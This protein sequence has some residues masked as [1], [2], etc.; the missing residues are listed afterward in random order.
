MSV[1][2]VIFSLTIFW[3]VNKLLTDFVKRWNLAY[4]LGASGFKA[5]VGSVMVLFMSPMTAKVQTRTT[6]TDT[7][8]VG[9][10]CLVWDYRDSQ[11]YNSRT[12]QLYSV[13]HGS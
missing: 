10:G 1:L 6:C 13:T 4:G 9:Q 2:S 5:V 11:E 8:S 3:S 12:D 7:V